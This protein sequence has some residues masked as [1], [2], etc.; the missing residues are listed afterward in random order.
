MFV[1]DAHIPLER[2]IADLTPLQRR[3]LVEAWNRRIAKQT[4]E[5]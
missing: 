2:T 4:G 1:F 5:E 3:W